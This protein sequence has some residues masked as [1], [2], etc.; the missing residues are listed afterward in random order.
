MR[1]HFIVSWVLEKLSRKT[2]LQIPRVIEMYVFAA[3]PTK[4]TSAALLR[5]AAVLTR[6]ANPDV[7]KLVRKVVAL[8]RE[9]DTSS[10]ALARKAVAL[11]R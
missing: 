7:A 8:A 1:L 2:H 9:T 10:A 3:R 6:I 11:A 4:P 5:K